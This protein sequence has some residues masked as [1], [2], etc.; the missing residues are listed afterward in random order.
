MDQTTNFKATDQTF[1]MYQQFFV[2]HNIVY[3][4]K[5]L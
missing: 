3:S 2:S 4:Y 5:K 1:Y